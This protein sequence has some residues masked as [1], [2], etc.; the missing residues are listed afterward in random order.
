MPH[1]FIKTLDHSILSAIAVGYL[2]FNIYVGPFVVDVSGTGSLCGVAS[3]AAIAL[4]LLIY[5]YRNPS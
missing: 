2:W 5:L 4:I 3:S 1:P